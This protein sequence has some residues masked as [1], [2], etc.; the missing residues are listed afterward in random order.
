[1]FRHDYDF[2]RA[3]EAEHF[4]KSKHASWELHAATPEEKNWFLILL[5]FSFIFTQPDFEKNI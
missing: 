1:M 3:F 2:V 4:T 5:S